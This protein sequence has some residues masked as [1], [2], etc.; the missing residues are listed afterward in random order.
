M[1]SPIFTA[2]SYQTDVTLCNTKEEVIELNVQRQATQLE[3]LI[4]YWSGVSGAPCRLVVMPEFGMHGL[5]QNPDG[6][7]NGVA[8]DIPGK[9]TDIL[10]DVAVRHNVYIAAHAWTEYPDLKGRPMS[11]GFLIDP[12]GNIILKHHKLVTTKFSESATISPYDVYDWYTDKFGDD[13]NAFFPVAKTEIGNIGF[14]IC[15]EGMYPEIA[16]GMMLNGAEIIVRPNA[17]IE[18]LMAEPMDIMSALN[19]TN[20]FANMVYVVEANW[21][22][23]YK[24]DCPSGVGAGRSSIV[25]Y[26]GRLLARGSD[27]SETGVCAELNIQSLRYFR[28]NVG[29]ASRTCYMPIDIFKIPYEQAEIWPKNLMMNQQHSASMEEWN[30]HRMDVIKRRDDIFQPS[31]L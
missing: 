31:E 26:Q 19:R 27:G 10:A 1:T 5:C 2:G 6:T 23:Y 8:I 12:K 3:F 28:E 14:Q 11:I 22:Q 20:A 17:W 15:G 29:F 13:I 30:A 7:W 16:R 18:P 25:D 21:A 4:P 9:E 24:A